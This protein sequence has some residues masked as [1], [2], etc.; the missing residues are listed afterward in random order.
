MEGFDGPPAPKSPVLRLRG[1]PFSAGEEDVRQFF[2][3]FN[4]AQV[5]VC[6][7]GG[8]RKRKCTVGCRWDLG[9]VS[10]A[11]HL[12]DGQLRT[13]AVSCSIRCTLYAGRSTGEGYVQLD[14]IAAA[15]DA[16]AKLHRQSMGHRYVE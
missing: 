2:S 1:L 15:A 6:R 12:C 4:V 7:R 3:D 5:V 14:S 16:I 13:T 9:R 11:C 10:T 8:K